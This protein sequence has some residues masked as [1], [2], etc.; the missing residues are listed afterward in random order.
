MKNITNTKIKLI[1]KANHELM[2]FGNKEA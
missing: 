2:Y 1:L